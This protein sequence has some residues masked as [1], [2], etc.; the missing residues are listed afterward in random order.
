MKKAGLL[1]TLIKLLVVIAII[2]ILASM[3]LPALGRAREKA[4]QTT[5]LT[6]LR[7]IGI[8]C[9]DYRDT[10]SSMPLL[11]HIGSPTGNRYW[12]DYLT[13]HLGHGASRNYGAV[14][15]N[16]DSIFKCP[17][18]Y[19]EI[20]TPNTYYT[21]YAINNGLCPLIS[22]KEKCGILN[23][24]QPS[25][26]P[27]FA[28]G[29]IWATKSPLA[30]DGAI[31]L[32]Y[33]SAGTSCFDTS[34]VNCRIY[35]R[36]AGAADIIYADLHAGSVKLPLWGLIPESVLLRVKNADGKWVMWE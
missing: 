33:E 24:K 34:S 10:Y 30:L 9:A 18:Q 22:Q 29:G 31:L 3:L 21:S 4:H 5:C 36:H 11:A 8:L 7:Q 28:D 15:K 20:I 17:T 25:R 14:A 26:T 27:L 23:L 32:Y 12:Y 35:P 6:R 16:Q 1:F 2:A 19:R 13:D